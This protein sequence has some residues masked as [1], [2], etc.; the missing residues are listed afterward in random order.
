MSEQVKNTLQIIAKLGQ[1]KCGYLVRLGN[2][3]FDIIAICGDAKEKF[4]SLNNSL[5]KLNKSSELDFNSVKELPELKN[6]FTEISINSFFI[7]EV[8][9]F[10]ERNE[11]VYILLF[12]EEAEAFNTECKDRIISV[13]T[14]LSGQ[15][16]ELCGVAKQDVMKHKAH[17]NLQNKSTE[18]RLSSE[19]EE[20]F[21]ILLEVAND[22]VFILDESGK[23]VLVN[24]AGILILEYSLDEIKGKHFLELVDLDFSNSASESFEEAIRTKNVTR[25]ETILVSKYDRQLTYEI[26]IRLIF[27]EGE[28]AGMLGTGK[29]IGKLK[30][31]EEEIRKLKPKIIEANRLIKLERA[32][33]QKHESLVEELNRLKS[34]FISNISHEFRTPLASIIGFSETIE[35]D[36]DLPPEMKKEFNNV[37][38]IEGKRLAKLIKSVLDISKIEE[39]KI[40]LNRSKVNLVELL[41][42]VIES[43]NSFAAKKNIELNF[44]H[45]TEDVT[46]EADMDKL[47]EVFEAL[48][49][50]AIKFT[51]EYGRVKVIANNL[52]REVEII[53][54]DTGIGI[55]EK[56]LPYIFQK[57]YRVSRPGSEIPG[58]GVGLVFVK[59][60]VD[61][62]K[63]LITVQSEA[64]SGTSFII[65]LPKN[66]I[67][68]KSEVKS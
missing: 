58:T 68:E 20:N 63:G 25:F 15:V 56:D 65:K 27:K 35:L 55:P 50:N 5:L 18:I 38:L 60:M 23:I 42:N 37:I 41:L 36:P 43:N 52:F 11:S 29:S 21:K 8:C 30:H 64:G 22:L 31:F 62:H 57:F 24:E 9:S 48:I 54:S 44:E 61:L 49:S 2:A 34:E 19:W 13:L 3:D 39:G 28:I 33:S 45:P 59:Q 40:S 1:S 4:R 7:V 26:S 10:R 46:L 51:N 12:S 66:L 32:R 53:V 47:S 14:I 16:K 6:L 17:E 67:I